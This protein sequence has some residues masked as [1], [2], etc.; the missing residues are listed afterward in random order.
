[1]LWWISAAMPQRTASFSESFRFSQMR[2]ASRTYFT[3]SAGCFDARQIPA[4]VFNEYVIRS[5]S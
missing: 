1:M 5:S 3:P 2:I 4:K